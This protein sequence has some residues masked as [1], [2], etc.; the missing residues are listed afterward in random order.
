MD[1]VLPLL[2]MAA[3]YVGPKLWEK[4]WKDYQS[5]SGKYPN[6]RGN[7]VPIKE[8]IPLVHRERPMYAPGI[9]ESE[10]VPIMQGE[11]PTK[12]GTSTCSGEKGGWRGKMDA[13]TVI[14]GV[15]FAEILQPPR[16][17]RPFT[18]RK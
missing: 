4:I 7:E 6:P 16:A 11:V 18:K 17:Y 3:V 15:I 14:N 12:G 8:E 10:A 13:N 5:K 1:I 2:F 9:I